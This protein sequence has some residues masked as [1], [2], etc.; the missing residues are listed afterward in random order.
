M[1]QFLVMLILRGLPGSGKTTI[2]NAILQK[3]E[4]D[5]V[6]CSANHHHYNEKGDYVWN[7]D[8]LQETHSRCRKSA[9]EHAAS[10][11]PVIIIGEY[12]CKSNRQNPHKY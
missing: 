3:Y 4:N 12:D 1:P 6:V 7:K 2:A 9:E 11:K 5:A 10:K 8:L